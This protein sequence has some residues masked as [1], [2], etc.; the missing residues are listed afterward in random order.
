[1]ALVSSWDHKSCM[2]F[3]ITPWHVC[4]SIERFTDT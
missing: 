3:A 2:P 1:M 4:C